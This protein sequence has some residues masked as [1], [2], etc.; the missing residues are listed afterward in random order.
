M[1]ANIVLSGNNFMKIGM[2]LKFMNIGICSEGLHL[3]VEKKY[4]VKAIGSHW[5]KTLVETKQALAGQQLILGGKKN[6]L[7][8]TIVHYIK[9]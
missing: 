8:S 5:D 4:T 9:H 2:L 7:C 1:S 3:N 6:I